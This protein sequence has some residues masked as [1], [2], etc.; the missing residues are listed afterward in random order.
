[1]ANN[2]ATKSGFAAEAQR[3]VSKWDVSVKS[4]LLKKLGRFTPAGGWSDESAVSL[5]LT[6]WPFF[7]VDKKSR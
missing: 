4:G 7:D 2:R 3:K 1:M 5:V 6:N